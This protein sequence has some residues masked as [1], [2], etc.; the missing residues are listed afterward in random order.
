ML[1]SMGS[2]PDPHASLLTLCRSDVTATAT[3]GEV[4]LEDGW[5]CSDDDDD[6][7]VERLV[8]DVDASVYEP[9]RDRPS[10]LQEI[11]QNG[12]Y[13]ENSEKSKNIKKGPV[14]LSAEEIHRSLDLR[15]D[16][17]M[18]NNFMQ[19]R[20]GNAVNSKSKGEFQVKKRKSSSQ[21][22]EKKS[23]RGEL[24][25]KKRKTSIQKLENSKSE[26]GAFQVNMQ[27]TPSQRVENS[28]AESREFQKVENSKSEY[29]GFQMNASKTSYQNMH[30]FNSELGESV[31]IWKTSSQKVEKFKSDHGKF[32]VN[33]SETS[34]QNMH[35]FKSE[36][37]ESETWSSSQKVDAMTADA[38]LSCNQCDR[39]YTLKGFLS[40][41][42]DHSTQH[43]CDV[44]NRNLLK[45]SSLELQ[46]KIHTDE[47]PFTCDLCERKFKYKNN[48]TVHKR[49]HAGY[50]PFP[51]PICGKQFT[52]SFSVRVHM[53]IHTGDKP[54][55]C[56]ICLCKFSCYQYLKT[57]RL[58]RHTDGVDDCLEMYKGVVEREL[59]KN[60]MVQTDG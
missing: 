2:I 39:T 3:T 40:R 22:V 19:Y 18:R 27:K 55:K 53:R 46:S 26:F 13:T 52:R 44:C 38:K 10:H 59:K 29:E 1:Q 21:N 48:L 54:F 33:A 24:Q 7:D 17:Y 58:S 45:S 6:D 36:R 14:T 15:A 8:I 5:D 32:Q 11:L 20:A 12:V 41:H 25:M 23:E 28:K 31:T 42:M 16:E 60:K 37:G 9:Q 47:K 50:K 35:N 34:C 57:H 56:S 49:A 30:N 43:R 4:K 51:C